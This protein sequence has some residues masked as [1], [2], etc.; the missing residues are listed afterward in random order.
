M[1]R[2]I[3]ARLMRL[4]VSAH[5]SRKK[6]NPTPPNADPRRRDK[7]ESDFWSML[8]KRDGSHN[9]SSWLSRAVGTLQKSDAR[10]MRAA[11]VG[12]AHFVSPSEEMRRV[13]RAIPN[14]AAK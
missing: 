8:G 7:E 4:S 6:Q 14:A 11:S 9:C 1:K 13:Q 10:S 2:A 5:T 3:F 12:A